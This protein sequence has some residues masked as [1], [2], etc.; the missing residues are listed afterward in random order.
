MSY[1]KAAS[2]GGPVNKAEK[3]P[4]PATVEPTS[5]PLGNVE[6]VPDEEFE[7]L[8]ADADQSRKEIERD[9]N[10]A[11]HNAKKQGK[12]AYHNAKKQG[13][14]AYDAAAK[15]L[16]EAYAQAKVKYDELKKQG[17]QAFEE[18]KKEF[19]L[20]EREYHAKAK[21]FCNDVSRDL[22]SFDNQYLNGAGQRVAASLDRLAS[23][24]WTELQNPVVVVQGL[25]SA[26]GLSALY[27]GYTDRHRINLD[28]PIV[29]SAHA[30][31]ITG[32]VVADKLLFDKYYPKYKKY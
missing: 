1:A 29:V 13:K 28:N 25:V 6:T 27:I 20:I 23:R 7:E 5:T 24:V 14:E 19:E 15:K 18:Y 26:V 22:K 2:L 11:A 21:S 3:L 17:G 12:E 4:Q 8:K 32:L 10:A 30:A 9:L 16:E 31:I